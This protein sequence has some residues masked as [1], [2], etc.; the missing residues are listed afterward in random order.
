M[1][2]PSHG[3][4]ELVPGTTFGGFEI[5]GILGRGAMGIVYRARDVRLHRPVALKV[6]AANLA[7]DESFRERFV[8]E[9][10]AAAMVE[11]PGIVAVY[12]SGEEGDTPYI[13]MKLIEGQE[14]SEILHKS[15]RLAPQEALR[16]LAPIAS[17]LDA[18]EAAGIVHRDVKPSNIL[19]PN[20]GS[21]AVLVDF[22]IGRIKGS[23]RA[24]QSG[25]WM[26]TSLYVAPEQIRSGDVDGRADQYSLACVLYELLTGDPPFV[27]EVD[28]QILWAHVND[29][30]PSVIDVVSGAGAEADAFFARALAKT[31]DERFGSAFEMIDQASI[32]FGLA[33]GPSA[34]P[35]AAPKRGSTGTV[36]AGDASGLAT[37]KR[38]STGTVI[39][40][41]ANLPAAKAAGS[42]RRWLV[43]GGAAAVMLAILVIVVATQ[44]GG[45]PASDPAN[46]NASQSASGGTTTEDSTSTSAVQTQ[47]T[48]DDVVDQAGRWRLVAKGPNTAIYKTWAKC[49]E[50]YSDQTDLRSCVAPV[51]A[52]PIYD[53]ISNWF[54]DSPLDLTNA[55]Q[56]GQSSPDFVRSNQ[57]CY[58]KA[59]RA[60]ESGTHRASLVGEYNAAIAD[61]R[62][63]DAIGQTIA[64]EFADFDAV[65]KT[66]VN[67][68]K[69]PKTYG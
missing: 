36:I 51:A 28:M 25:S 62:N 16:I 9:A 19:V 2:S 11:H 69:L 21:G 50:S 48:F 7:A 43:L 66:F 68:C 35:R 6:V 45:T 14:L 47:A 18:A 10:R 30:V 37:P 24:T 41:S 58:Q 20:D 63:P 61:G 46:T 3:P 59:N 5:E 60:I 52:R 26:G 1:T 67:A 64:D 15:G 4:G 53:T 65:W 29:P 32:V 27:R 57:A 23:S 49:S 34:P 42:N 17:A 55:Y 54:K 38:A 44:G 8:A 22:G 12:A 33:S 56:S 13:A 40:G 39:A 31:P